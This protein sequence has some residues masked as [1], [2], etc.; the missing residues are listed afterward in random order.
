M[1]VYNYEAKA[2]N[3]Q[4]IKGQLDATDEAAVV[5]HLRGREFYPLSIKRQGLNTDIST[6][7]FKK[8]KIKDISLFARQFAA[9]ITSGITIMRGLEIVSKQT[10]NP[11][12]K[13]ILED[14]S[15]DVQK[16]KS[17]SSSLGK[18]EEF[19]DM[20]VSMV[21]VGEASGT[22]D[23]IMERTA[24]YYEKQYKIQQKVKQATSYPKI[25]VIVAIVAVAF[26]VI[27]VVPTFSGLITSSGGTMPLPTKILMGISSF[28]GSYWYTLIAI[29]A[30]FIF[31]YKSYYKSPEGR[32]NIDRIKI[33]MPVFGKINKKILTSSFAS[34]FGILLTSGVQLMESLTICSQVV[35]NVIVKEAL[36]D[37][38]EQI[39]KGHSL[40]DTLEAK[41]IFPPMLTQMV[42]IGEES[43]TLDQ[44]LEKTSDFYDSEVDT[45]TAQ[46]TSMI[47]PIIIVVLGGVIAFIIISI[48]LP[49]F[50]VYSNIT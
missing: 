29:V 26:L 36:E 7:N 1:P 16:G 11:K 3:G 23:N 24:V 12:L 46:L 37:T 14:V 41:D 48:M 18:H 17:L 42:K 40:G 33:T 39:K 47:E 31:L 5:A 13:A 28:A 44:V 34:T 25:L 19:P 6:A 21:E 2:T 22:L 9:L 49:M 20:F 8:V 4:I 30:L 45:A 50:E 35:G 38:R 32:R 10:E 15:Q 27:K 43:G